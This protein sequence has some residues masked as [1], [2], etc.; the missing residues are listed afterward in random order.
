[1]GGAGQTGR[2]RIDAAAGETAAITAMATN[3]PAVRG[4]S[5]DP[6]APSITA[7]ATV[8]LKLR[9]HPGRS[10]GISLQDHAL[11]DATVGGTGSTMVP[12][13]LVRGRNT[14]CAAWNTNLAATNLDRAEAR[15]CIDLAYVGS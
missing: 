3:P 2:I 6:G 14:I 12:V 7:T 4:P 8:M 5:W 9:G 11:L 1:M 15:T 13:T 10:F